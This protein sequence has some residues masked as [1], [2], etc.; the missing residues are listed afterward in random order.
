MVDLFPAAGTSTPPVMNFRVLNVKALTSQCPSSPCCSDPRAVSLKPWDACLAHGGT[1]AQL[2]HSMRSRAFCLSH[3][4]TPASIS[5]PRSRLGLDLFC[6]AH[7]S[8]LPL[9]PDSGGTQGSRAKSGKGLSCGTAA[10]DHPSPVE[11]QKPAGPFP[12]RSRV[13]WL[14][15]EQPLSVGG[16]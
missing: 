5:T 12:A 15:T 13:Q 4:L 6:I 7:S 2:S 11:P 1:K 16:C 8:T 14:Q 9:Y 10:V 3:F